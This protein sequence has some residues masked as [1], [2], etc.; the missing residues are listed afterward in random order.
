MSALVIYVSKYEWKRKTCGSL[1]LCL[2]VSLCLCQC[3]SVSLSFSLT[4]KPLDR[5]EQNLEL[6]AI[7]IIESINK[8]QLSFHETNNIL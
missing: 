5:E 2:S 3:L 4:L 1:S 6:N 8:I 7:D